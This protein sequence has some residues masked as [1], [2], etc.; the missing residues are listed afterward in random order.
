[1]TFA[2]DLKAFADKTKLAADTVVRTVVLDVGVRLVERSPVGDATLWKSPPPPGYVGGRF[3]ANWQ[4][5]FGAL[6]VGE[7]PDIDPSG[8]ASLNRIRVGVAA[9][10]AVGVHYIGNALPYAQALEDGHSKQAPGGMVAVTVVEFQNT[11]RAATS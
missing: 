8:A 6:P 10:P 2:L 4:Y 1:M 7:L 11:V 5:R 9:A 3:R